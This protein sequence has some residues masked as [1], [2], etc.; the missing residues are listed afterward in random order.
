MLVFSI[1]SVVWK[2]DALVKSANQL[3]VNFNV[4]HLHL[5]VYVCVCV[6]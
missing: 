5:G 1:D 4:P 6:Y 3:L 2:N